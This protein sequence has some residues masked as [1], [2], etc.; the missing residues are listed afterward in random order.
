MSTED[1]GAK[2]VLRIVVTVGGSLLLALINNGVGVAFDLFL[3]LL[4][5]VIF[6]FGGWVNP[7]LAT[8]VVT[9]T[10]IIWEL[11]H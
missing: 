1:S 2:A 4:T 8:A 11:A 3:I 9:A 10:L 5:W 7:W 6:K